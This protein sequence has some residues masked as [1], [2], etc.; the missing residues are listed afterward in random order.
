MAD[1]PPAD[2]NDARREPLGSVIQRVGIPTVYRDVM[3]R[4]RLEARWGAFFDSCYWR[5]AYEPFDLA[6]Y[7]P[8]F[9]LEFEAGHVLVEV[10]PSTEDLALAQSKIE[11]SGWDREAVVLIDAE[12]PEVGALME[13]DAGSPVWNGATVFRCLSCGQVSLRSVDFS[14]RC[15]VCGVAAGNAHVG[16]FDPRDS[17]VAAGNRVQ[18]RK[19]V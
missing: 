15:R 2:A 10:K 9:V 8:D 14:W 5:W 3:M 12:T 19:P 11:C 13:H 7:I 16:D 4:S 1:A 17:W 18:W 6:G